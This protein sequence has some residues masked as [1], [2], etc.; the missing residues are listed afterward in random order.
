M[1]VSYGSKLHINHLPSSSKM[2]CSK[3]EKIWKIGEWTISG[4]W[5]DRKSKRTR[6]KERRQERGIKWQPWD[7]RQGR[8]GESNDSPEIPDIRHPWPPFSFRLGD[9]FVQ[10]I[11]TLYTDINSSVLVNQYV[12]TPFAAEHSIHQGCPLMLIIYMLHLEPALCK[13]QT[14]D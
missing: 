12:S 2:A 3:K 6:Q 1:P 5:Q 8:K 4:N 11:A 14:L 13:I 10:W 7:S 9:T